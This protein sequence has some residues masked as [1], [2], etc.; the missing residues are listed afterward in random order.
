MTGADRAS[1][2]GTQA[3]P[4]VRSRRRTRTATEPFRRQGSHQDGRAGGQSTRERG[5]TS[6]RSAVRLVLAST[7]HD[8]DD[9]S[10]SRPRPFACWRPRC[11]RRRRPRRRQL[12]TPESRGRSSASVARMISSSIPVRWQCCSWVRA[13]RV[14]AAMRTEILLLLPLIRSRRAAPGGVRGGG[15]SHSRRGVEDRLAPAGR[16]PP[17][18][19]G[20]VIRHRGGKPRH[21]PARSGRRAIY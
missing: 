20:S 8:R 12:Y 19:S 16:R 15:C 14:H 18:T 6:L 13:T 4:R 21:D 10:A 1:A 2:Q 3:Q 7:G 9:K 11:R 17:A 5:A